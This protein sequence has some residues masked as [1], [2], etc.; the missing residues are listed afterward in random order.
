MTNNNDE[1]VVV[2]GDADTP[3][4]VDDPGLSGTERRLVRLSFWQTVLSVAGVFIAVLALYA[5]LT[6]SQAVR[7]QTAAA[8]WPFVQLSVEDFDTGDRAGFMLSVTNSGVGP[9]LVRSVRVV[10]DGQ[11]MRDWEQVVR[12]LGGELNEQVGRSTLS[13]RVLSPGVRRDL[14]T[15]TEQSLARQFQAMIA[16][17]ENSIS[18][19]YCSIFDECWVADSRRQA[20]EPMTVQ[21]CPDYGDEAF[22]N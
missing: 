10:L 6:E 16:N 3:S 13:D 7:Q 5:A 2:S 18:Y 14:I 12:Q 11:A 21:S 19:C 20:L 17:P 8:V 4:V 22:Q 1:D 9:A 15:V